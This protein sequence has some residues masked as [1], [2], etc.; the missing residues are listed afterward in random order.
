MTKSLFIISLFALSLACNNNPTSSGTATDKNDNPA[1]FNYNVVNALPHDTTSFTEGLLV[2]E[3]QLYESTGHPPDDS[4]YSGT[5][6]LFGVVDLK[7]GKIQ[8]KAEIDKNKYFGEGIAFLNGKV[9]QLTLNTKIGFI[10]DAKTFKKLGEFTFPVSEGWGMTTDGTYLI[11][12]DGSSNLSYVDPNTFRLVKV[13]GVNDNNGYISN[14]NELEYI[15]GFIYANHYQT[16]DIF[17]IDP[18][19]GKIVGKANFDALKTEALHKY[20][21]SIEMNGI[22]YDSASKKVYL[23]GKMWPNIY[24]I[25]LGN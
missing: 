22:A 24:E 9:Y 14:L 11:M 1:T 12:S 18:A 23:T 25:R 7:T 21:G 19:S 10:Y 15:D 6:S 5:R 2:H 17:K 3:G 8:V 13:L 4:A 16:N 20:P